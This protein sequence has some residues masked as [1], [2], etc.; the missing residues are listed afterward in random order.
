MKSFL[1]ALLMKRLP[2]R[3][4]KDELRDMIFGVLKNIEMNLRFRSK[5]AL[6]MAGDV[7]ST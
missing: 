4:H 6:L 3:D 1:C 7:E 2:R 5:G